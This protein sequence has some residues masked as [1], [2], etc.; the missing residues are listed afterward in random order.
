MTIGLRAVMTYASRRRLPGDT[1]GWRARLMSDRRADDE[2]E[3][4]PPWKG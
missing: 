2:D 3:S 1:I 4:R